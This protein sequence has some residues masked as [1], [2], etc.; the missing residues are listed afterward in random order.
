[1]RAGSAVQQSTCVGGSL[2]L[3]AVLPRESSGLSRL[4]PSQAAGI[5]KQ[6]WLLHRSA[7]LVACSM[8]LSVWAARSGFETKSSALAPACLNPQDCTGLEPRSC[9]GYQLGYQLA[10]VCVCAGI[11]IVWGEWWLLWGKEM[12]WPPC[13]TP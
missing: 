10:G 6:A 5:Y 4:V 12:V 11:S 8:A 1:M 9:G 7:R 3:G 2:K 13:L